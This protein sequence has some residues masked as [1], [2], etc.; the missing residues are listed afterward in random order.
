MSIETTEKYLQELEAIKNYPQVKREKEELSQKVEKLKVSL[1]NTL[2]ELSSLKELK[3]HL[4]AAQMTLEEARL[5]FIRAQDAEIEKRAAE[6][7]EKLRAEYESKMP[8]LAYQTLC[9]TLGQARWPDEIAKL[10]DT[11]AK[12][13]ADAILR[14]QNNWP[15]WFKKLY[16]QEVKE[17]VGAGLSQEFNARVETAATTRA[18]QR[19]EELTHA[20]WPAWYRAKVEPQ[21]A[22]LEARIRDN[23]VD[24]LKGRW[25]VT[26]DKCGSCFDAEL[27]ADGIEELLR[28]GQVRAEC[29][30]PDC[31]DKSLF[32]SRRHLLRVSLHDLIKAH[33]EDNRIIG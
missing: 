18:R 27:T 19:L 24:L 33:M 4:D 16:E 29:G 23:V 28:T 25:K 12:K 7:F 11:E 17:K 13:N 1:D 30:N 22:E 26:C 21:I 5:D 31:E 10:I 32:S 20:E 2:K 14:D 15:P 6:R 9:N 8:D 3:A